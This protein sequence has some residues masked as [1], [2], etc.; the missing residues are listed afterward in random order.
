MMDQAE[1]L[2]KML[3][4][5]HSVI[6]RTIAVV[7]GK[8]GV[9]KTNIS[10]N[11]AISL[12]K[13][14]KKVLIFDFDIG[15]GNVNVLLGVDS[16]Y[17]I[18]DFLEH[19]IPIQDIIFTA[20]NQISYISAGNGFDNIIELNRE[21]IDR[22]LSEL[23]ELQY[24]YD[25]I[26]FD[27]GA[28]ATKANIQILLSVDDIFV[29]TT[30][31][32]TAITDAYSMMKY[33]VLNEVEADHRLFLICNRSEREKEG[34]QTLERLQIAMKKFLN[35]EILILGVLPEDSHVRKSVIRQVPFLSEFPR[36]SIT[37]YLEKIIQTYL[38]E[39]KLAMHSS[40]SNPFIRKLRSFFER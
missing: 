17:T 11:T 21:A 15:M 31:E 9:G 40:Q 35:K 33:I 6:A 27:M 29:I 38:G 25:Y 32:P 26:I 39:A 36:S 34:F 19:Q 2:R 10:V 24:I 1:N 28:G 8:G 13:R 5:K 3:K 30:P 18:S 14:G 20:P 22:L 16:K 37:E 12:S 4:K 7:S 23:E